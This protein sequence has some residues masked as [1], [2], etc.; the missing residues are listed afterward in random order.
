M[1]GQSE[2]E[3]VKLTHMWAGSLAVPADMKMIRYID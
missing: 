1:V 2:C 3:R